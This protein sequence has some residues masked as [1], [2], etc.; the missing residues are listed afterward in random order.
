MKVLETTAATIELEI[1]ENAGRD[2]DPQV[3]ME[4]HNA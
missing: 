2:T 1:V 4:G 3:P